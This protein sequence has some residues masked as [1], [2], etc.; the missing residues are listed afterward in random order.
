MLQISVRKAGICCFQL[1]LLRLKV[2][3]I[4]LCCQILVYPVVVCNSYDCCYCPAGP[5]VPTHTHTP[6]L[7]RRLWHLRLNYCAYDT[8]TQRIT[9]AHTHIH[10]H[11]YTVFIYEL[12]RH[13]HKFPKCLIFHSTRAF[14]ELA[15]FL[16]FIRAMNIECKACF[17][18]EQRGEGE[19]KCASLCL[20]HTWGCIFGRTEL[21]ATL[22]AA[23]H[24]PPSSLPA[25][26]EYTRL[27]P[28]ACR[29]SWQ[30]WQ[31]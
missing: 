6:C 18:C 10:T 8:F 29:Q 26:V 16:N 31:I 14:K 21:E 30:P 7:T 22:Q 15:A 17:K 27:C 1:P 4:L 3:G 12:P 24:R 28:T 9:A 13:F 23:R 5:F 2:Q 11:T 20:H 19:R 25:C